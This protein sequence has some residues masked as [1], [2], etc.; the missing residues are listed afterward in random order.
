MKFMIAAYILLFL[1]RNQLL[2]DEVRI[3][4]RRLDLRLDCTVAGNK[5]FVRRLRARFCDHARLRLRRLRLVEGEADRSRILFRHSGVSPIAGTK[6]SRAARRIEETARVS[7]D[8]PRSVGVDSAPCVLQPTC[9]E[10]QHGLGTRTG[11]PRCRL[12][13]GAAGARG[14]PGRTRSRR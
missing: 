8:S 9:H 12:R 3:V 1:R 2:V 7:V 4:V 11:C 14:H 6:L 5:L 10:N 13:H